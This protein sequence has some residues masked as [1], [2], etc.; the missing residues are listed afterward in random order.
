[1]CNYIV[2][3]TKWIEQNLYL[4]CHVYTYCIVHFKY[5]NNHMFLDDFNMFTIWT[6]IYQSYD[7]VLINLIFLV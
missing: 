7:Y 4:I 6:P 5:P 1:M 3:Q 2:K